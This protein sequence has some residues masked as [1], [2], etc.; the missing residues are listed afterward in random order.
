PQLA[1]L[2]QALRHDLQAVPGAWVEDK[3]LTLTVHMRRVPATEVPTV[4][5]RVRC[6]V[7]AA[8]E[9]RRLTLRPGKAVVE[10]RPAVPWDKGT[11]VRWLLEQWQRERPTQRGC[12][13]YIGDDETDEDAFQAL[14]ATGLGIVVGC[15]RH[16]SAAHYA[17]AS[18][19][20]VAQFLAVLQALVWPSRR[21]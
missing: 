9:A 21:G 1:T 8:P 7:Q 12:P 17:V 4:Q 3:G 16:H 18:P 19:A 13:V 2:V 15:E 14:G 20:Q 11:A 10:V 6:L 5:Y